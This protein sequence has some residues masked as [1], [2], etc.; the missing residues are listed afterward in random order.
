MSKRFQ[1]G[2][3]LVE[4]LVVIAIIGVLVGLLL[5][6]VQAAREAARRMSCS[7]N[8]KQIGLA[9]HN[10]HD[11][12]TAVPPMRDREDAM[13]SS[14]WN[15]QDY[16][17]RTRILPYIEQSALYDQI[18][19][20]TQHWWGSTNP[21][22]EIVRGTVVPTFRCPTDPGNG[23]VTWT[24]S[25][26]ATHTGSPG[27]NSYAGTNYFACSGPD[28][29]IRWNATGL[30]MFDAYRNYHSSYPRAK[31]KSFRDVTDGLSN[32]I[33]IAEGI[34][35]FP[36]QAGNADI[37]GDATYQ[38]QTTGD[39]GDLIAT[40][41]DNGCP[42]TGSH[43]VS[44]RSRGNSWMR[45][46]EPCDMAFTTL[47]V[48]NSDLWDCNTTSNQLMYGARS[49]HSGG[50]QVTAGDGSVHFVSDSIDFLL[51]RA[52]GGTYDGVVASFDE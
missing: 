25:T 16:S 34:M 26:G 3:T 4:L 33:A 43:H 42:Q 40:A 9:I 48:P 22:T 46:Y 52:L 19:F 11:T 32:T 17:W 20:E 35:G 21:M 12:Y 10:Y 14:S 39:V 23:G 50:V 2:F 41:T 6:A 18:D 13:H 15:T 47:M 31:H 7:N 44:S 36:R 24:D 30:G 49:L 38:A 37:R 29:R 51:W 1:R 45:G 8:L 5:P 28:S 27:S